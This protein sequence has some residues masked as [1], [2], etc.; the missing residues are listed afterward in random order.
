MMSEEEWF[1]RMAWCKQQGVAPTNPY[2]W[3]KAGEE[4]QLYLSKLDKVS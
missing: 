3:N 2:F 1:W 4:Y